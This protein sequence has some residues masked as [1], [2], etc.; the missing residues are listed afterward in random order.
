[1]NFKFTKKPETTDFT[2]GTDDKQDAL[3]CI[4]FFTKNRWLP[5]C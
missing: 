5:L 1:M 2:Y 4:N 3:P